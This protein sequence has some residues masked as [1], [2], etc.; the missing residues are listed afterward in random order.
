MTNI[1][2]VLR[3]HN[4]YATIERFYCLSLKAIEFNGVDINGFLMNFVV[5]MYLFIFM[6]ILKLYWKKIS[7]FKKLMNDR[8]FFTE[9]LFFKGFDTF[10]AQYFFN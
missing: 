1:I 4:S 8:K 6:D 7:C 10:L 3:R 2:V 5:L 9:K